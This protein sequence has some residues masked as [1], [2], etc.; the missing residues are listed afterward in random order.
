MT[1]VVTVEGFWERYFRGV[2]EK[3]RWPWS[4]DEGGK[5]EAVCLWRSFCAKGRRET[6]WQGRCVCAGGGVL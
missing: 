1:A 4:D 6:V 3:V 2:M 5:Q